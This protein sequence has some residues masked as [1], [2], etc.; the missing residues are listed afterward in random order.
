MLAAFLLAACLES[1]YY[2]STLDGPVC[3]VARERVECGCSECMTWDAVENVTV[4][5]YEIERETVSTGNRV[6]VGTN[7]RTYGDDG[8][9]KRLVS[10]LS[11]TWCYSN[12]T[13]FPR[14]G[15]LYSYRV[16]ACLI[17]GNCG[18]WS[19]V[20]DYTAAPYACYPDGVERQCYPGDP[21]LT[22]ARK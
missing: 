15:T 18:D 5:F 10:F 17:G 16:R 12:D 20:V 9:E 13:P 1:V 19:N 22:G 8:E 2:P 21:L 14:E 6:I 11:T 7:E 3:S 4:D